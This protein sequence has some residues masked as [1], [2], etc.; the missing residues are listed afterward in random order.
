MRKL[1]FLLAVLAAPLA[2]AQTKTGPAAPASVAPTAP[3]AELS[4]TDAI[5]LGV[6]EGVTEFLPISSTGHLIV[7]TRFLHLES[8][9]PLKDR[10]GQPLWYRKKSPKYPEGVPLTLKLA[11]DT[12]NV[13]IQFGAIAAVA[14]L[15]WSQLLSMVRGLLGRDPAGL[16]L[17]ITVLIAFVPAAV[18]GLLV[19]DW[20]DAHL[21]TVGAVI[22]AQ[23]AGA[24]L[25]LYAEYWRRRRAV[26]TPAQTDFAD[27][28]PRSAVGIGALQCLAMWPGTSRSMMT[29]VGGY[30]SGLDPRR[31]AEFSF[32]LGFVTLSA[33]T[34][35]KSYKSGAA[36]IQVFGWSHVL[37]G[38]AVAAVTAALC[39]RFLVH[40]LTRHGLTAFAF[41]RL[42]LA[43]LLAVVFYLL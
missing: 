17:L 30:F 19:H 21:F 3:A 13:V 15:Y 22:I 12:Y 31:S 34:V 39:V 43:T 4:T 14:L 35:F 1:I 8:E 33:A 11:A 20:I 38:A 42:G 37:L 28:T 6:V 26:L 5:I 29:I 10:D 23:V 18:I 32:I 25:M 9:E 27:L 41:Y 16:R 36:M 2:P 24:F 7:A 40:W